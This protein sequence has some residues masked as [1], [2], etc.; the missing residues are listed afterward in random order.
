[1]TI[2]NHNSRGYNKIHANVVIHEFAKRYLR[3]NI[4]KTV[5]NSPSSV[6]NK[7]TIRLSSYRNTI[8]SACCLIVMSVLTRSKLFASVVQ[9]P[10]EMYSI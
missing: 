5:N 1:M 6:I 10:E 4:I 2:Q 7:I 8:V 3:Y 9:H